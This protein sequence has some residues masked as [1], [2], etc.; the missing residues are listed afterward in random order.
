MRIAFYHSLTSGGSKREAYEFARQF[1]ANGVRVDFYYPSTSNEDFLPLREFVTD[2]YK[3]QLK[4]VPELRYRV[5]GL[6]RYLDLVGLVVNIQRLQ[7]L[8]RQIAAKINERK[9]DFVFLNHDSIVQ[10]PYLLR[11]LKTTSVYYC[12]EPIREFYEAPIRRAYLEPQSRIDSIQREWYAPARLARARI[13]RQTDQQNVKYAT[14]LLTNS[15]YSAESIYRAYGLRATVSYL[16]VNIVKFRPLNIQRENMVL[17]V[18]AISPLK[19]Y[20]FLIE[21]IACLPETTRP[22]LL[23]VGN[24]AST[25]ELNYLG[26]LAAQMGVKVDFRINVT[27]E[28]LVEVYNKA[29]AFVYAPILE[30][31]GLAPLEAMACETPVVAVKEGGVRES[32]IDGVTG[33]L[34]PRQPRIFAQLLKRV[35][36]D[37]RYTQTLGAN[38]RD[39]VMR[40]WT[41]EKAYKRLCDQVNPTHMGDVQ[42]YNYPG[43]E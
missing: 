20:D 26:F 34:S 17:S 22:S 12:A 16:G 41:W 7:T 10:S 6:T 21:A 24:T 39:E 40:F 11:Y 38:G 43:I 33:L 27:E 36:T 28:E 23:I 42:V 5:P 13:I 14:L 35:L 4:L 29:R 15:F 25:G 37:S 18:G 19:G 32:I 9:Y 31:F 2:S 1:Q 3:Y 8:A 30:P